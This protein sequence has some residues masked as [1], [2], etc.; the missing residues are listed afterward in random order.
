MV[1][2]EGHLFNLIVRDK[3]VVTNINSLTSNTACGERLQYNSLAVPSLE[4]FVGWK[5]RHWS[6]Y[7]QHKVKQVKVAICSCSHAASWACLRLSSSSCKGSRYSGAF[8]VC[9][10]RGRRKTQLTNERPTISREGIYVRM[11]CIGYTYMCHRKYCHRS[12]VRYACRYSRC[13][14]YCKFHS[15]QHFCRDEFLGTD[16]LRIISKFSQQQLP[17]QCSLA[18]TVH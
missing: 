1:Q 3:Q 14:K 13:R 15:L 16:S 7:T 2:P 9:H 10:I 8:S 6:H 17:C 11:L 18:I 4:L 12:T 5:E